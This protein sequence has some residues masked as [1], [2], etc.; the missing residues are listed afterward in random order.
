MS[1]DK[2][3]QWYRAEVAAHE[4]ESRVQ[5]IGQAAA[6]PA[7]ARLF[8]EAAALRAQADALLAAILRDANG[9]TDPADRAA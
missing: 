1:E 5:R 6:D 8:Q 3:L 4:A 9:S 2:L 7:A